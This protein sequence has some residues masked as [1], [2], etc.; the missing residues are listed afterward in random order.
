M[1]AADDIENVLER[2]DVRPSLKWRVTAVAEGPI[3]AKDLGGDQPLAVGASRKRGT[4]G[5]ASQVGIRNPQDCGSTCEIILRSNVV[6][7]AVVAHADL[8]EHVGREDMAPAD[9]D[10]PAM[11]DQEFIAAE[12]I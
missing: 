1:L 8:V 4:A 12:G 2:I 9:A 11:V 5:R 7:D 6:E 10:V 3:T